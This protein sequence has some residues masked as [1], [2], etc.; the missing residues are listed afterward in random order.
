MKKALKLVYKQL[1]LLLF[2][3]V[4]LFSAYTAHHFAYNINDSDAAS[5]LVL[6]NLLAEQNKIITTDWYYGSE[7]RLFHSNLVYMPL[8]KI[9]HDWQFI[10]FISILIFQAMLLCSYFYL[11][12]RMKLSL[13]AYFLSAS[14]LLLPVSLHQGTYF[15]YQNY[16]TPTLVYGFLIVGLY[17]SFLQHSGQKRLGQGL[18]IAAVLVLSLASCL[19]GFRQFPSALLPLFL[20]ALAVAVKESGGSAARLADMRR[21][22][23]APLWL[24][25]AICAV[26]AAGLYIHGHVLMS[27]Y[28]SYDSMT[29]ST[30]ALPTA[31]NFRNLLV[32]YLRL[33]GFQ[34][35]CALFSAEGLLSLGGVFAAAVMLAV[36]LAGLV[37]RKKSDSY[38]ENFIGS[39]YPVAMLTITMIFLLVPGHEKYPSYYLPAFAWIFPFL[40]LF[41]DRQTFALKIMTA[42]QLLV[43]A[44]CLCMLLNGVFY[45]LYYLNPDGKQ[46]T[47]ESSVPMAVDSTQRL[48]GVLNYLEENDCEVGY[49]T[50]WNANIITEATD[51]KIPMIRIFRRYPLSAYTYYKELT[52]KLY[53]DLSFVEDK[54]IFLLLTWDEV[55]VFGDSEL[56]IYAIPTYE[57]EY[58]RIYEF[59]F[60]TEV[61]DYLLAQAYAYHQDDIIG[62][63]QAEK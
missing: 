16:Y 63:L 24:A 38:A 4:I 29:G 45:N 10:R 42:K 31:D 1:P 57:D 54:H 6:G 62:Q 49:A 15:L 39:L 5:E 51:G 52:S 18:R 27:R 28:F 55:Y 40:G 19:N 9:F 12:R 47:Y 35:S 61:W 33:F 59:D 22:T 3:L 21:K 43:T 20:T 53:F 34:E 60:S 7:L 58:F 37:S 17:L 25:A 11:S 30:I 23:F 13:R 14:L 8:F 2:A 50:F 32:G 41:F 48:S 56:G 46:V 44:A 26:G 36:G